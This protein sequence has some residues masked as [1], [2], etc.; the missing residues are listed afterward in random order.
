MEMGRRR[1]QAV[2]GKRREMVSKF[3]AK[4]RPKYRGR[5]VGLFILL[6]VVW[7]VW[8]AWEKNGKNINEKREITDIWKNEKFNFES[9]S[10]AMH[11]LIKRGIDGFT[12]RFFYN[13]RYPV[14]KYATVQSL[15]IKEFAN[16]NDYSIFPIERKGFYLVTEKE[17]SMSLGYVKK[18][19][20]S[21]DST[22][23]FIRFNENLIKRE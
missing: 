22:A 4:I 18:N 17:N 9:D 15:F 5:L 3:W 21:F 11:R 1:T 20:I 6:L 12:L 14:Y 8:S 13:K 7:S 23:N 10:I 2:Y 16:L 19:K